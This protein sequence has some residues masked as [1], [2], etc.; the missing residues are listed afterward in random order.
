[1]RKASKER[2]KG[3]RFPVK[4]QEQEKHPAEWEKDL[5][6]HQMEGQN[7]GRYSLDEDARTRTAAD[8]K[9]VTQ[10]LADFSLEEL[11]EVPIV[12]VGHQLKEGAVYLDLRNPALGPFIATSGIRA[13]EHNDFV[14]K[15]E[16]PYEYWNRLLKALCPDRIQEM[17][18]D[19]LG[20]T[21]EKGQSS[22]PSAASSS[23]QQPSESMIDET[24]A[25]S[26]PASDPPSWTLGRTK[27]K[28][29]PEADRKER[30]TNRKKSKK[31]RRRR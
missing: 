9:E 4:P 18:K 24:L 19:S 11:R 6:P 17:E 10:K 2:K 31:N 5:N 12:P 27:D 16:V 25:E 8:A 28:E 23:T 3:R 13:K 14:P 20:K 21:R 30:S 26:F 1:M 29:S 7:I 22:H 15:A